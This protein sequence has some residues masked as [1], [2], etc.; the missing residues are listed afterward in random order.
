MASR[1]G[2]VSIPFRLGGRQLEYDDARNFELRTPVGTEKLR[3]AFIEGDLTGSPLCQ[4][5][6]LDVA[7]D[8]EPDFDVSPWES[9]TGAY[10]SVVAVYCADLGAL[11]IAERPDIV[12][13]RV[14]ITARELFKVTCA[15]HDDINVLGRTHC[16][17]LFEMPQ[18]TGLYISFELDEFPEGPFI[19][20]ADGLEYYSAEW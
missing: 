6:G 15:T 20:S 1:Q 13:I 8:G 2:Q 3:A 12:G 5:M 14:G 4:P 18:I 11:E 7:F 16:G 10:V 19:S 17:A 9:P